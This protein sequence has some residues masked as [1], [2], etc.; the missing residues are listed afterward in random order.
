MVERRQFPRCSVSLPIRVRTEGGKSLEV[1]A[2]NLSH[3]GIELGCGPSTASEIVPALYH[4][5]PSTT[6]P[7]NMRLRLPVADGS[8]ASFDCRGTVVA[9]RRLSQE[10][11]R[12]SV[13]FLELTEDMQHDLFRYLEQCTQARR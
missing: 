3:G 5:H 9:L 4:A 12:I 13:Q 1:R 6:P 10:E 7:I 8:E 2:L 11:Y